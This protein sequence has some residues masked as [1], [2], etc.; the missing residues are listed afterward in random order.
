MRSPG[1]TVRTSSELEPDHR[2]LLKDPASARKIRRLV[3]SVASPRL[4]LSAASPRPF[5]SSD[6]VA[7]CSCATPTGPPNR[8]TALRFRGTLTLLPFGSETLRGSCSRPAVSPS[9]GTA[10]RF[11]GT[12]TGCLSPMVRG[13]TE[14]RDAEISSAPCCTANRFQLSCPCFG[15]GE[16]VVVTTKSFLFTAGAAT[17]NNKHK[18]TPFRN[19]RG[20]MRWAAAPLP[21]RVIPSPARLF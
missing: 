16:E 7:L 10:F 4:L 14:K 2:F 12:P 17:T 11:R 20:G 18:S 9:R 13:E 15:R 3:L 21:Q 6:D 19:N 5:G 1:F 8:G